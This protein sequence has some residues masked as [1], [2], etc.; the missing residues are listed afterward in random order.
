MTASMKTTEFML[1]LNKQLISEKGVADTT[2]AAYIRSLYYLNGKKPFKTLTFIKDTEGIQKVIDGY[3]ENTK[4]A[5]LATIVSVLSLFKDKPTYKKVYQHY[6]EKM[7][8]KVA[9]MKQTDT[10]AS[11]KTEKEAENWIEWS[12]VKE[13]KDQLR[14]E[15]LEF[16]GNKSITPEQANQLLHYVVLSL[17][18]DI[19]PRR[20]QDYLDMSVVVPSKKMPV[21]KMA[22]DKNYLVVE[23]KVPTE[24]VFNK[25]KTAKTYGVQREAIPNTAEAPLQDAL[26]MYLKHHP[27]AKGNKSKA[28][29]YKFLVLPD[30]TPLTAGNSI[31]RILNKV[32]NKKIGSSMLR[33]IYLSS[34][35]DIKDMIDTAT[36]MGHSLTEQKKYLREGGS[37]LGGV[38]L[39][40]TELPH[41]E[42]MSLNPSKPQTKK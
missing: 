37:T 26:Q 14:K 34:K 25:Y 16:A 38:S 18:A 19:Q 39:E 27:L 28:T 2:A 8:E 33:H 13:K 6:Y 23:G 7:S 5:L 22:T 15:V 30:G 1:N 12:E 31:T 4:K 9:E 32:F 21:D 36:G 42:S 24:F 17:Y 11:Q 20:N 29:E 35:Y 3:A 10:D 40:I 41:E